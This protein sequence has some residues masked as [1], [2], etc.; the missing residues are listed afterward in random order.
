MQQRV[1]NGCLQ[2]GRIWSVSLLSAFYLP[3]FSAVHIL[4]FE[5]NL[6]LQKGI[7]REF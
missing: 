1:S 2:V 7:V 3:V 5:D 4:C 6:D